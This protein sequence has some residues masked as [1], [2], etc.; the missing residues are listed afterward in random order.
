MQHR[1]EP[2]TIDNN[3]YKFSGRLSIALDDVVA[4]VA[5]DN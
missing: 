4:T 5:T 2:T 3:T 1:C